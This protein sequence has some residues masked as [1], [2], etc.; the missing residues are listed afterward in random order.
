MGCMGGPYAVVGTNI[1]FSQ[2]FNAEL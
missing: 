1:Y 2:S